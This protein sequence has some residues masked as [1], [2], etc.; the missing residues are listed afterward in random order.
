MGVIS[1]LVTQEIIAIIIILV[2]FVALIYSLFRSLSRTLDYLENARIEADQANKSKSS[3]LATMSHEIRTPLN[4]IIGL[5]QVQLQNNEL[6]QNI[7]D[8]FERIYTSGNS[9]LKIINDIL[10][11]SKVETGVLDLTPDVYDTPSLINDTVQ[12]NIVRIGTKNI[13]FILDVDQNL[14]H[15]VLGDELRVKQIL[16]NLISNAIKYTNNG[17][18]KL[19]I[20]HMDAGDD[21]KL[22]FQIEDTG[23]GISIDDQKQLFSEY[24]RFNIRENLFTEGTGLGLTITK[25]LVQMMGGEISVESVLG[26]GSTFSVYII[27]KAVEC[28]PIG[29]ETADRLQRFTFLNDTRGLSHIDY[30]DLHDGSIL[31]V[32]DVEI[33]LVVADAV[34]KPYNLN[35]DLVDSGYVAIERAESGKKYD[36]IFMDHMMPGMDGIETTE[37][38]RSMGYKGAIIALT[39]NALVG[40]EEL[41][42]QRGFDGF[43]SKPIDIH[44]LDEIIFKYI[45]GMQKPPE[46]E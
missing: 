4:A 29:P 22:Y 14:P 24:T 3:F 25:N 35:I 33:N 10:D 40:N 44:D 31:V 23:A 5:T 36:I 39:A 12:L 18:I 1:R 16:N 15:K 26:K 32:D 46:P 38:L 9:L 8:A 30:A 20:H 13:D 42:A 6:P 17:Y 34:L 45:K 28:D 27:Q 41:F 37:K 2:V 11:L 21:V 19:K 43:I 7:F